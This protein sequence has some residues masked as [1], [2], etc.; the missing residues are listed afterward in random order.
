MFWRL[1]SLVLSGVLVI[2]FW[3]ILFILFCYCTSEAKALTTRRGARHKA[4]PKSRVLNDASSD[5]STKHRWKA[6]QVCIF[7][8]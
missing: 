1:Y 2:I 7:S 5:F 6:K 8:V 4:S 3:L